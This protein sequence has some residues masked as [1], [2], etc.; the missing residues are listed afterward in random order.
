MMISPELYYKKHLEGKGPKKILK[1]IQNIKNE[2]NRLKKIE[3]NPTEENI[4][5]RSIDPSPEVR[6]GCYYLYLKEAINAL[7]ELGINY[8]PS[9]KEK[10]DN[11]V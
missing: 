9:S 4:F 10:K 11:K 3:E 2:I 6:I 5:D 1:E 7:E 8:I